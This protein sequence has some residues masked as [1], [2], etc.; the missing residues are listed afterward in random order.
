M[1]V[2]MALLGAAALV[3]VTGAVAW[4][5]P[6]GL[7]ANGCHND[8]KSGGYHCHKGPNAGKSFSSKQEMLQGSGGQA[9]SQKIAPSAPAGSTTESR[10]RELKRLL[11]AGLISPDEYNRKRSKILDDL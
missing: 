5:H 4:A 11:D 3:L 9:T 2:R 10:L 8:R 6:G 1:R 7:D